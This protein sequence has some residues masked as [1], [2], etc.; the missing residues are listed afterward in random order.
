MHHKCSEVIA[1][2]TLSNLR[3]PKAETSEGMRDFPPVSSYCKIDLIIA[4]RWLMLSV[5]RACAKAC[6]PGW[7]LERVEDYGLLFRALGHTG[8]EGKRRSA[9]GLSSLEDPRS[10]T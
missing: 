8:A 6:S 1:S 3:I 4:S 10:P 7:A 5:A 2:Q 9:H